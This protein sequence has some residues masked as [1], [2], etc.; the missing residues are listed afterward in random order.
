LFTKEVKLKNDITM[1]ELE[2]THYLASED[3]AR[4]SGMIESRYRTKDGRYVLNN[5]DLSRIRLSGDEFVT[6]LNGIEKITKEDADALIKDG[7]YTLGNVET[8]DKEEQE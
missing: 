6:G 1:A 2:N 4:R 3:I 5:R 8:K 7:G